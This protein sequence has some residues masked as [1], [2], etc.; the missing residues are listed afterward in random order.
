MALLFLGI[1][2]F[3]FVIISQKKRRIRYVIRGYEERI[4]KLQKRLNSAEEDALLAIEN[5]LRFL[6]KSYQEYLSEKRSFF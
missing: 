3:C 4:E 5:Q 6:K 1:L 2:S